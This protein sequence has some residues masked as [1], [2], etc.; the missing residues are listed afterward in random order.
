VRIIQPADAARR[1]NGCS[2]SIVSSREKET[3]AMKRFAIRQ[4]APSVALLSVLGATLASAQDA[5]DHRGRMGRF[6]LMRGLSR[7]DLTESQKT[8]V[9][10]I[11]ES[12]K[13]TFESLRERARTDREALRAVSEVPTPD[14]SAVGAAFLKLR[15]DRK[16]LR[17]ERESAM[18]EIRSIL[19]TE[20]KEKLDSLR[21]ERKERFRGRMGMERAPGR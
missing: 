20:Q 7:L 8:E 12:R 9:K 21:Q 16:A 5:P 17:A 18:Q 15:A 14:T 13:T 4:L 11:M 2:P 1:V 3:S 19:T 6:G 10:R